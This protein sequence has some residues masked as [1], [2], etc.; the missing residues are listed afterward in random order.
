MKRVKEILGLPPDEHFYVPD[1]V[2][3]MYRAAGSA[4]WASAAARH[5]YVSGVRATPIARRSTALPRRHRSPG[6][7]EEPPRVEA[8]R[9][10]DRHARG[11]GRH[12]QRRGRRHPSDALGRRRPP[13]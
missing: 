7:G 2:A 11:N 6:L 1:D 12:P 3:E 9:R 4:A 13:R 5:A 10:A 8:R